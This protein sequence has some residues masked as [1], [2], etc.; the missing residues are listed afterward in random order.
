[1]REQNDDPVNWKEIADYFLRLSYFPVM[2]MMLD[3]GLEGT[4]VTPLASSEKMSKIAN[5]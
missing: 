3:K 1:V 2:I 5:K 4:S